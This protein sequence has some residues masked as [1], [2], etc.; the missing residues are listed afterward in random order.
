MP[1]AQ[2]ARAA[3]FLVQA[4]QPLLDEQ[5][6]DAARIRAALCSPNPLR[7]PRIASAFSDAILELQQVAVSLDVAAAFEAFR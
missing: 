7:E 5:S 3:A 2:V 6:P 4:V 1:Q